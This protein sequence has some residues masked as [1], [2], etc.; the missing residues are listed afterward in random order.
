MDKQCKYNVADLIELRD[1]GHLSIIFSLIKDQVEA[2]DLFQ[3]PKDQ[4]EIFE[5]E[6]SLGAVIALGDLESILT[7][8]ITTLIKDYE[9]KQRE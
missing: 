5:R 3:V 6:R 4:K 2:Y 1:S 8:K 9:R 7:Q